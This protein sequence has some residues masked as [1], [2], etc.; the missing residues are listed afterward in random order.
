MQAQ[1][2]LSQLKDKTNQSNFLVCCQLFV[3]LESPP[4]LNMILIVLSI[5]YTLDRDV[6]KPYSG[7]MG[8]H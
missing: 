8:I 3:G 6:Y 7:L 4:D 1:E 5:S 2:P